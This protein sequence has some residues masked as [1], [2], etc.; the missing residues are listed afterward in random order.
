MKNTIAPSRR[1]TWRS[2]QAGHKEAKRGG[3]GVEGVFVCALCNSSRG[4]R[5]WQLR[6][7]CQNTAEY[8]TFYFND[9]DV[10]RAAAG[11]RFSS[12]DDTTVTAGGHASLRPARQAVSQHPR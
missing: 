7:A 5:C 2:G 11:L 3:G 10:Q 12:G 4:N 6:P 1:Q 8:S 9:L